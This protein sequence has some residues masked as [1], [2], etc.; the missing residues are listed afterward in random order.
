M[1][2]TCKKQNLIGSLDI[3]ERII[4]TRSPLQIIEG[5]LLEARDDKL[6]FSATNLETS[7]HADGIHADIWKEGSIVFPKKFISLVKN[8]QHE[9]I[10]IKMGDKVDEGKYQI[11]ITNGESKYNLCGIAPDQFPDFKNSE[12]DWEEV[13]LLAKDLKSALNKT[14]FAVAQGDKAPTIFQGVY[15]K[16]NSKNLHFIGSDTFHV[17][18]SYI[19]VEECPEVKSI[20]PYRSL[21]ELLRILDDEEDVKCYFGNNQAYFRHKHFTFTTQLYAG[22][23]PDIFK[24]FPEKHNITLTLKKNL[25][26][27]ALVRILLLSDRS[28][29]VSLKIKGNKLLLEAMSESGEGKEVIS[30]EKTGDDLDIYLNGNLLLSSLRILNDEEV[31]LNFIESLTPCI[32]KQ[33]QFN[34]LLLPIKR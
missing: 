4:P 9:I 15:V 18:N 30:T 6:T 22:N 10:Q 29:T 8:F 21:R 17:A 7:V 23:Y 25:L 19:P 28:S 11:R 31:S 26:E 12:K 2:V 34:Y 24:M 5:F 20:V 16:N 33:S 1:Q 13:S 14:L 32:I 3:I 27:Q